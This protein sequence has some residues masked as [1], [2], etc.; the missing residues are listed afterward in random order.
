MRSRAEDESVRTEPSLGLSGGS[1][2]FRHRVFVGLMVVVGAV[3]YGTLGLVKFY[4]FRVGVYDLVIFDQGVRG[5]ANFSEPLSYVKGNWET[6]GVP[7]SLLG[8]HLSPILVLLA[9]LYW[10]YDGPETLIVA[11]AILFSLAVVPL[12]TFVRRTLGVPAAY[13]VSVAYLL[14]W[15]IAEAVSFHFHEYAFVPLLTALVFERISAGKLAQTIPFLALVLAVKED[16]GIFV[17]GLGVG[18]ALTRGRRLFGATLFVCGALYMYLATHVVIPFFGGQADR[19]WYY[20]FWGADQSDAIVGVITRPHDVVTTLFSPGVKAW[21][22]LLLLGPLFFLCLASPYMLAPGAVLLARMLATDPGA[23][24]WWSTHYH[25][26]SAVVMALVCAGVD[27]LA[28]VRRRARKEVSRPATLYL[29]AG[30]ALMM[31]GTV[32]FFALG[33]LFSPAWYRTPDRVPAAVAALAT[34]P[35]GVLVETANSLGPQISARTHVVAWAAK[36]AER[37]Q[38]APW[39]VADLDERQPHFASVADQASD[40]AALQKR[41]YRKVFSEK[42]YVVLCAPAACR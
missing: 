14:S 4:T 1:P 13:F 37:P 8:D 6:P 17:A 18:L 22:V 23:S 15:P 11:Q 26:N 29:P 38:R 31:V 28:R 20:S 24:G 16:M 30:M 34:V 21:T 36:T 25:Y 35:D 9:P 7:F 5:Y 3:V 32:P 10:I 41:G 33:N 2:F 12:W 42:G 40:V 27:G 39:V 19:Y